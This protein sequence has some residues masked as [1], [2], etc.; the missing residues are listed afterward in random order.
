MRTIRIKAYKFD[1]LSDQA[2]EKAISNY[3]N[4]E[5]Y[6]GD[7]YD[8]VTESVKAVT[9]LFNLKSGN[10][11][12]DLRTGHIDDNIL[13]LSGVRLY[14]FI[15]NNYGT[16]LFTP[17]Y[18]KSIPREVHYKAFICEVHTYQDRKSTFLYSKWKR[19]AD[20]PLT[21]V[22]YDMDILEPV[23]TFLTRPDKN[24]TFQDLINDIEHAMIKTYDDT[25]Q[26]INSDEFISDTLENNDYE[27]TKE[28]KEIN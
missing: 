12:S 17:K 9:E 4:S 3:R 7:Y 8:E 25:E 18:I 28:G 16:Q 15:L 22:C 1:E 24:T 11:Y 6:D 13:E 21:G 10:R 5:H 23:Y 14:K 27:F 2:K 26:W 20:C 19:S